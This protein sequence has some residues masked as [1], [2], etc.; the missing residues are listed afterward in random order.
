MSRGAAGGPAALGERAAPAGRAPGG[1]STGRG[2]RR[3]DLRLLPAAVAAWAGAVWAVSAPAADGALAA[4]VLLLLLGSVVALL[5]RRGRGP[6]RGRRGEREVGLVA[7]AVLVL[8]ASGVVALSAAAQVAVARDGPLPQWAAEE[9]A[10]EVLLEVSTD[11]RRLAAR[12]DGAPPR[13]LLRARVLEAESGGVRVAA[14]APV[15]VL[16]GDSWS[17]VR[18]GERYAAR[19]RL[20]PPDRPGRPVAV[21]L[22][23]PEPA[24]VAPAPPAHRAAER[25][26]AGLRRA[27]E[28]LPPDAAGLVP[29]LVVGDTSMLPP[30]LE[31]DMRSVGLAH[32]TAVSG[33]NTTLVCGAALLLAGAAGAGRRLR[34]VVA[35]GVLA[36]F[37][38][39]ARPEPSVLRAAVM[40]GIGLL[41]LVAG[42]PGR[43]LPVLLAA[44]LV[45]L[46]L[47]PWL[48]REHGF[49]LSVLATAAL[50][51][52]ASSWTRWLQARGLPRWLAAALAVPAV[53]QAAC[54][55]VVVLLNPEV[56]LLSVPVNALAAPAVAPATVLGLAAALAAPCSPA[57]AAALAQ[58]AAVA[59]GWIAL[60]AR[61]AAA[62]PTAL[63]LPAGARGAVLLAL[64][65]LLLV[66][67]LAAAPHLLRAGRRPEPA[68]PRRRSGF[69]GAGW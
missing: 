7:G 39:L 65:T 8:A 56:N 2:P 47:D 54:G 50:L 29:A 51:L 1:D 66:A 61:A 20:R 53:A 45:L 3:L 46:A 41:G 14:A 44:V 69:R 6:A 28:G 42:R 12:P 43:G 33:A 32:L 57:V 16:G 35:G 26:R 5:Q 13:V 18:P 30:E 21:L 15:L 58:L 4:A 52:L 19:G 31:A 62:A 24:R 34:L 63:P 48:A 25:L 59:T 36:G 27:C 64:V 68:G 23:A 38:L 9:A 10:A 22:A 55:P 60:L 11:P 17:A 49:A 40:G 37:V 67:V